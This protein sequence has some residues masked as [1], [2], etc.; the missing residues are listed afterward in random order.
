[1]LVARAAAEITGEGV[2][3]FLLLGSGF[4]SR[5]ALIVIRT[6]GVQ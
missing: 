1:M 3:H 6:P 5:K 4:S 2:A